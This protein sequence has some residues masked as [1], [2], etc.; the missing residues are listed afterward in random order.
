MRTHFSGLMAVFLVLAFSC[1]GSGKYP[2]P[3]EPK[4]SPVEE[5]EEPQEPE[6]PSDNPG[7]QDSP[8][9]KDVTLMDAFKED[10]EAASSA[11]LDFDF[12][13]LRGFPGF[14]SLTEK[15]T[16]ILLLRLNPADPVGE[17]PAVVSKNYTYYGTYAVRMRLPDVTSVQAKLGARVEFGPEGLELGINLSTPTV[18]EYNA[19]SKFYIYGIDWSADKLSYWVKTSATADKKVIEEITENVP[20]APQKLILKY[21]HHDGQAPKYPYELEIDWAE[22][23]PLTKNE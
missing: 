4:P 15:G 12:A 9:D 3:A 1:T 6:E 10:F 19:A 8:A 13:V 23:T 7:G 18:G 17:G 20:Q 21:Y 14:P 11:S 5:P 22:Y 2:L 16:D